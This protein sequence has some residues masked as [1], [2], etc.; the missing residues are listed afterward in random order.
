[1]S[2][3]HSPDRDKLTAPEMSSSDQVLKSTVDDRLLLRVDK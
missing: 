1:M 2:L 3:N